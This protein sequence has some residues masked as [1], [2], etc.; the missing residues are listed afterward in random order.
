M[1][2]RTPHRRSA[3]ARLAGQWC[4][5]N[6]PRRT[7]ASRAHG[8]R[9]CATGA[10]R[11]PAEPEDFPAAAPGA[12]RRAPRPAINAS[13][14]ARS[15]PATSPDAVSTEWLRLGDT[16]PT[17][18]SCPAHLVVVA[19]AQR[20]GTIADPL[21]GSGSDQPAGHRVFVAEQL[22]RSGRLNTF[23]ASSVPA[24]TAAPS[25]GLAMNSD[26]GAGGMLDDSAAAREP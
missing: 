20:R 25:S 8:P 10:P 11:E 24:P 15:S 4:G 1:C 7:A 22:L 12:R 18:R 3:D 9:V 19:P 2:E 21:D 26:R 13:A 6:G 23:C 5:W 14:L 17:G 16:K